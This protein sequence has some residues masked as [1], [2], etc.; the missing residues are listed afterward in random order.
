MKSVSIILSA[1]NSASFIGATIE[2]IL[3]QTWTDFELIV[4]NDGSTDETLEVLSQFVDNRLKIISQSNQGQDVALN[5]GFL[6]SSGNY[7]KFMDS[8]DL[9]NPDMIDIQINTLADSDE[10]IAYGEWSRFYNNDP[11]TAEFRDRLNWRDMAPIDFLTSEK[12]GPMLQCGIMLIPRGLIIKSGLWDERLVLFNDTEFFTRLLLVS[13]GVKFSRG[14][15]LYYRSGLNTSISA[16][17]SKRFFESTYLAI[18]LIESRLLD[19]ENSYRTRTLVRNLLVNQYVEMYPRFSELQKIHKS[20]LLSYGNDKIVI[21]GGLFLIFIGNIFGWK[22]AK[23]CRIVRS[24]FLQ[25]F[26]S[27]CYG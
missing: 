22:F 18:I 4:V 13:K 14:A 6:N 1:Y 3:S 23:L 8:D 21:E 17:K 20:K 12:L 7:V 9:I 26:K 16:Q 11:L 5:I 10:Y 19:V 15:R 25:S 2:S 27:L 24:D